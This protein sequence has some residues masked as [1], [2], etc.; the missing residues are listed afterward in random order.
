MIILRDM[1]SVAAGASGANLAIVYFGATPSVGSAFVFFA[2][3]CLLT[4][5]RRFH[6]S[7][8]EEGNGE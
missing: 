8:P 4:L 2:I 7:I 6:G 3:C 5:A 1:A